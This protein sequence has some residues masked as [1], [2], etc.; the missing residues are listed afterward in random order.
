MYV[1]RSYEDARAMGGHETFSSSA[2]LMAQKFD[3]SMFE[4]YNKIA[5]R[6]GWPASDTFELT[7]PPEHG[8]L[9]AIVDKVST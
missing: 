5:R 4:N 6:K 2:N 8:P 7:D 3:G 9:S 1:V